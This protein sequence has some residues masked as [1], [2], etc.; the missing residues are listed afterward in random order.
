MTVTHVI[1]IFSPEHGGPVVSL[2]NYARGQAAAG[3]T[4]RVRTVEG[5]PDAGAAVRL[6]APIDQKVFRLGWPAK[7]GRSAEM[8]AY[9]RGESDADI[10]HLHGA[11]L[12]VMHYGFT[13]ARRRR[14]PY[15]VQVNGSFQPFDLRRKS[16]R[17]RLVRRWFRTGSLKRRHVCMLI[18]LKR[19]GRCASRGF[20]RRWS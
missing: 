5:Y 6:P 3:L 13:E 19:P 20:G 12:R 15:L 1:G 8:A 2:T 16:W 14:R 9:L 10:Y 17:K 18:R 7:L 4:V 11:W